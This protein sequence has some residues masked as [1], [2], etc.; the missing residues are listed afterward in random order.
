M[1]MLIGG[2]MRHPDFTWIRDPDIRSSCALFEVCMF[3]HCKLG[4]SLSSHD[5]LVLLSRITTFFIERLI[6]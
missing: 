5:T 3:L 4:T 6:L 1:H 2:T